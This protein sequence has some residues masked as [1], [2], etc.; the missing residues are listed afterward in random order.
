M[1]IEQIG[2]LAAIC[3][4]TWGITQLGTG[5]LSDKLGRKWLIVVG[6]WVQA[7]GIVVVVLSSDFGGYAMGAA[8][9]GF[10]T[11]MVYP[12]LLAAVGDVAH[13]SW[14]A[15]SVGRL[16]PLARSRI[17]RR[18]GVDRVDRGPVRNSRR[19]VAC[20]T[21]HFSFGRCRRHADDGNASECLM[22]GSRT[23]NL[24][25]NVATDERSR[26]FRCPVK[27]QPEARDNRFESSSRIEDA[28]R[29]AWSTDS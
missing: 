6:M 1:T 27:R 20:R 17:R 25:R 16:P 22:D 19:H 23:Q 13:P 5:P 14:R 8:L 3:P 10:G 15:S 2:T 12:T 28:T 24:Q 4:A 18:C 26:K 21:Y 9:L 7:A 11:A 29:M